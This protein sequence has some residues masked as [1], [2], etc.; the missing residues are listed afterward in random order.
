M[1]EFKTS[2]ALVLS[3]RR[4]SEHTVV[5]S[6]FTKDQGRC[7]GA[8]K[9]K[10]PPQIGSFVHARWQARLSEQTGR[11][12]IEQT[13]AFWTDFMDD[14]KRLSALMSLCYLL[15]YLL[16]ER[17]VHADLYTDVLYFLNQLKQD[18]FLQNYVR[19]EWRLLSALGF[20]LDTSSCAGGG[21]REN[22][23]YISPKSGRAVSLEKGKPYHDKLL[24]LPPFLWRESTPTR[25]DIHNGLNLT[26]Y[27]LTTHAGLKELPVIRSA[28]FD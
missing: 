24:I 8:V 13:N 20:G 25:H 7:R 5:L 12:Y 3:T 2:D 16:A 11:F 22:L 21:S 15:D 28:L 26:G 27:F 1:P 14:K 23:A 19:F 9:T 10:R 18:A 4:V 17:Q 6:L